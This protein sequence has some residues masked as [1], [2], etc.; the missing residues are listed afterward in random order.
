MGKLIVQEMITLDGFFAGPEGE[1]DWH[2]VDEEYNEYAA[3]FLHSVD[4]LLFGRITYR[5]ME[6]YWPTASGEIADHM[7]S[8]NKIVVS[9]T[10]QSAEWSNTRL[11]G[12]DAAE[13]IARL[14]RQPGKDIA[15]F[16]SGSLV[17]FLMNA[18]LIDEWHLIVVPVVLGKGKP[19]FAGVSER[20]GLK[21]VRT[22]T[23]RSG[24]VRL[25]YES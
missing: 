18:R 7:N 12:D 6:S 20:M 2:R 19:L 23:M 15:I 5:L 3:Q 9:K 21:L 16:G 25:Y 22:C 10:M 1:I 8:L 24:N 13:E 4:A 17:S 11:I 14:K